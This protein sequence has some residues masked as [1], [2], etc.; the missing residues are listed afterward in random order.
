MISASLNSCRT[1]VTKGIEN[2]RE[3]E[4]EREYYR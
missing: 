1:D 3:R 4:R 2:E